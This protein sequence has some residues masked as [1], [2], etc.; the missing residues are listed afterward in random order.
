M[1]LFPVRVRYSTQW[2]ISSTVPEPTLPLMYGSASSSA[3]RSMNSC[4]PKWLFSSTS[5]QWVLS[6]E[7]RWSLGPIPS[8]QWYS[9]PKQPPGQ[10]KLGM[11][12][13][14]SASTTSRRMPWSFGMWLSSP[15]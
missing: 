10:R 14:F 12:S 15:T 7:G 1:G 8:R 11:F 4:V 6:I 5:P 9:S 3:Q 2:L 13:A